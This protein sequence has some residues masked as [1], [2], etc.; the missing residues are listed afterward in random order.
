MINKV[1]LLPLIEIDDFFCKKFNSVAGKSFYN[2]ELRI[3]FNG[4]ND[5]ISLDKDL[6]ILQIENIG[7]N[8]IFYVSYSEIK[9]MLKVDIKLLEPLYIEYVFTHSMGNY[10][11]KFIRPIT[12]SEQVSLPPLIRGTV[13]LHDACY[14]FLCDVQQLNIEPDYLRGRKCNWPGSLRVSFDIIVSEALLDTQDIIDLSD[15]DLLLL[16]DK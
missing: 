15:E 8:G 12:V 3:N 5:P 7:L 10:G 1:L 13:Q 16:S 4:L 2:N 11:V 9:R 6:F 14:S